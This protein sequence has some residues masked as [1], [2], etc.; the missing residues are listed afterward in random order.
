[1]QHVNEA[2]F[3]VW[4]LYMAA[5]AIEFENGEVGVQ[6]ILASKRWHVVGYLLIVEAVKRL[7]YRHMTAARSTAFPARA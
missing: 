7:S 5:C 6:Q 2:G 4:R 3:R 1:M